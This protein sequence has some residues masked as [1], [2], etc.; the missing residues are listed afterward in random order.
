M[1]AQVRLMPVEA[2]ATRRTG[3]G[4]QKGQTPRSLRRPRQTAGMHRTQRAAVVVAFI[5]LT[6]ALATTAAGLVLADIYR[7]HAPGVPSAELPSALRHSDRWTDWHQISSA[8][9]VVAA[10][11]VLA[12]VIAVVRGQV[13]RGRKVLLLGAG[14][15]AVVGSVVTMMTRPLVE[16]DQ[17][18][19]WAVTVGSDIDGYWTAA[20]GGDVRFVLMGNTEVSQGEYGA[21][22]IIHL[23]A[24]AVTAIALLVV[25]T[26]LVRKREDDATSEV[27]SAA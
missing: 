3:R 16:W 12:L 6:A 9:L 13:G 26:A 4:D 19:I 24:P 11:V 23:A 1:I 10:I 25:G 27:D 14:V 2:E 8:A 18:A 17:L 5:G 15:V 21:A 22:L 7:P 20:F